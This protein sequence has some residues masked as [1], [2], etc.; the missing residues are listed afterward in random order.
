M[1]TRPPAITE[2][3]VAVVA[4][5]RALVGEREPD[6]VDRDRL[7]D[8][9]ARYR[10]GAQNGAV[11]WLITQLECNLGMFQDDSRGF[12]DRQPGVDALTTRR[13]ILAALDAALQGDF[14]AARVDAYELYIQF[15]QVDGK[16]LAV[17]E[18]AR[19]EWAFS[20]F[21]ATTGEHYLEVVKNQSA[22]YWTECAC[23]D[24]AEAHALVFD[25]SPARALRSLAAA[26]RRAAARPSS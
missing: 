25:P 20:L 21:R 9:L 17:T 19:A 24:D 1:T 2:G 10:R 4:A 7:V 22:A 12:R 15:L 26:Q 8:A 5:I 13:A 18:I 14:A 16:K 11:S 3:D 6:Q 23:I